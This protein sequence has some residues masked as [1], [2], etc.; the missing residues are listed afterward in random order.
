MNLTIAKRALG[1]LSLAIGIVAVAVPDRLSRW[2]GLEADAET[3]SA[4]GAREIA[5]GSGL[6]S[7]VKPGPWLW[8]RVGGDVMD[9]AHLHGATRRENPNRK[10]ALGVA[11]IV[12]VITL[13]DIAVAARATFH[14]R[15]NEEAA[16]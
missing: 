15:E 9:L 1:F 6:L 10:L 3:M 7:P 12:A 14:P 13:V 2:L 5:S 8:L 11:A 4:F 16:E